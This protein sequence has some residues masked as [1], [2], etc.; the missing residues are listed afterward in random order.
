MGLFFTF[1]VMTSVSVNATA[2]P[3]VVYRR[4]RPVVMLTPNVIRHMLDVQVVA[5][6][7]RVLHDRTVSSIHPTLKERKNADLLMENKDV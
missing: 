2:D 3:V 4:I 1:V 6:Q 7:A 5:S